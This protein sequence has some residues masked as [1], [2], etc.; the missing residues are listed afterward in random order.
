MQIRY[1]GLRALVS[2]A[3]S[4]AGEIA[5]TEP[6]R[7]LSLVKTKLEEAGLWLG[8]VEDAREE[9]PVRHRSVVGGLRF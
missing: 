8:K 1:I 2:A 6:S 5:E 3:E 4:L 9:T 7:E